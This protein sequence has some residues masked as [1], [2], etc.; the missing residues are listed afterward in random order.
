MFCGA[1]MRNDDYV[2]NKDET[3]VDMETYQADVSSQDGNVQ[4]QEDDVFEKTTLASINRMKARVRSAREVM[5]ARDRLAAETDIAKNNEN[6]FA[7]QFV[8]ENEKDIDNYQKR[9][10][11]FARLV[12][13]R[14]A[15][16]QK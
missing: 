13:E 3:I 11:A 6:G 5:K 8:K 14:K 7:A 1:D 10:E 2:M 9:K 12:E 4:A 15:L 16:K